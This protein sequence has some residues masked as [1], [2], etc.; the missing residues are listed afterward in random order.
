VLYDNYFKTPASRVLY[1][2]FFNQYA[3]RILP[4]SDFVAS[5]G[6]TFA[7]YKHLVKINSDILKD[8]NDNAFR[9][10]ALAQNYFDLLG[11]PYRAPEICR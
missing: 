9:R 6:S 4:G 10:I 5:A 8:L 7:H 11:L 1:V 3:D 2:D